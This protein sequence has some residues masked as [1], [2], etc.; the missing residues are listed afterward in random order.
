MQR[1]NIFN[2]LHKGLQA[3]LY[4]T[5]MMLQQTDFSQSAEGRYAL[6]KLDTLIHLCDQHAL[7]EDTHL[8]PAIRPFDEAAIASLEKDHQDG[9]LMAMRI[10]SLM[11]TYEQAVSGEDKLEVARIIVNANRALLIASLNHMSREEE[12]LNI[13]LWCRFTDAEIFAI[14]QNILSHIAPEELTLYSQWM[15][16]G[17]NNPEIIAWLKTVEKT[18]VGPVFQVLFTQAENELSAIRWQRIQEGLMEG[19]LVA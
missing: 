17:M 19:A 13:I 5:A 4:D 11:Q 8:L 9:R 1:Y 2:Q 7:L 6:E 15:I 12:V 14:E 18:A 10:K 16:R 3:L